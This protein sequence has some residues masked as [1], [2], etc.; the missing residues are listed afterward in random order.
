METIVDM[1]FSDFFALK[2]APVRYLLKEY[3][4]RTPADGTSLIM[5]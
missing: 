3:F 5:T 4:R 1:D 2:E